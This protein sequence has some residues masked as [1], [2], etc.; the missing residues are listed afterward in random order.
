MFK[1]F[2]KTILQAERLVK[3]FKKL[4]PESEAM[5]ASRILDPSSLPSLEKKRSQFENREVMLLERRYV[6]C[7]NNMTCINQKYVLNF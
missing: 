4:F 7:S 5:H 1:L 2:V 6:S 3:C